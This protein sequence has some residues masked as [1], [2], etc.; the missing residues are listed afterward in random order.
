MK[1]TVKN[2]IVLSLLL[3]ILNSTTA[4]TII[5]KAGIGLAKIEQ[6]DNTG[7]K[8][9]VGLTLGVAYNIKIGSTLSIQPELLFI[10]KGV[11]LDYSESDPDFGYSVSLDGYLHINYL[12]LPV[13]LRVDIPTN[14]ESIKVYFNAGP[15]LGIGL[16]GKTKIDFMADFGGGDVTVEKGEGKVK[17]GD[18]PANY[19][20]YDAYIK[21][22]DIGAQFG[23]GVLIKDKVMIDLRYGIG[24]TDIVEDEK[25]KNK[26][27][28]FTLGFPI[29]IK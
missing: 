5:P 4:Q 28:Q 22:T 18:E 10:Q 12:E 1:T 17:F 26:V 6:D 24:L 14:T 27:F 23:A 25:S 20:G 21:R 2:L 29:Q 8:S 9:R 15:S 11:K 19:D 7:M 16:G 13:L 3:L